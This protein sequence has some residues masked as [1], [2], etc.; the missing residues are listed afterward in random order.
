MVNNKFWE[1]VAG[2]LLW[3]K[4]W[5]SVDSSDFNTATI[6]W[7]DG[8]S[9]NVSENCID[10]HLKERG[11][12]TAI[13]WESDSGN[14]SRIISYKELHKEVCKAA[15]ALTSLGV[16]AGDIVTIYLPM[17][18]QAAIAMLACARIGATHSVV[19]GG[20]SAKSLRDR[21]TDANSRI[22][23]TADEG[24]R[25]GKKVP[26]KAT[27]DIAVKDTSIEKIL[28]VKHSGGNIEFTDGRDV[29]WHDVVD[30]A[31]DN[32]PAKPFDSECPLFILYTSGSTGKPKGLM[33]TSAGYLAWA[34]YTHEIIFDLKEDD[35]YWCTADVGWVTGHTY[36][37]YGAL[38]NGATTLMF[39]G[40]PNYPDSSRFWQI[41]DKYKVTIFYT[42]P[43]AI[44]AMMRDGNEWV[45]KYSRK[46]LRILGSVGE[47]INPEAWRWYDEVVGEKRCPIVDTWWQ[48]ETGATLISPL[49]GKTKTKAG[50]ATLPLN[51]IEPVI[52]DEKGNEITG[53]GE[54]ALCIKNAWPSLARTIYGDHERYKNTYFAPY[55]GYYFSGDRA[56]R[57]ADGYYWIEGRMDDV[58]NVSGHRLGT[59]EIESA[60][61]AHEKVAEAAVVGV[62][63]DI[64]GEG[65]CAYVTLNKNVDVA[66]DKDKQ[67]VAELKNWVREQIGAI[68]T[69]DEIR[70]AAQLPKTRSGKIMRRILRKIVAGQID[71][72]GDTSTLLNPEAVDELIANNK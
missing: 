20:F 63:H 27:V 7:F 50:S 53:E 3:H 46:S 65:I 58:L 37:L 11:D 13:I 47:P 49:A 21:I 6:K 42:A 64:K 28:L 32:F 52:L 23:I 30:M 48:T 8:G 36:T 15:N 16:K 26:L 57:D 38:A 24:V 29:W 22:L 19:F 55:A 43:T 62:P 56:R 40:V 12:K 34:S 60:L 69:P 59:A 67:V 44:R 2:R 4:S 68:A 33:H 25:G 10:R 31:D 45:K 72:I 70:F 51:G 1:E 39:E 35:V 5:H 9:L 14:E 17:I 54:G 18:P 66:A 71:Q 61:V 41:V